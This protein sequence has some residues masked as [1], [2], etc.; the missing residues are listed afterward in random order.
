ME[1]DK[2]LE[3]N[4]MLKKSRHLSVI[5]PRRVLC[6]KNPLNL[7]KTAFNEIFMVNI[8]VRDEAIFQMN[9]SV[10]TQRPVLRT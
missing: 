1:G 8:I 10:S 4:K 7:T 5:Q 2:R 6:R 3:V 9:G